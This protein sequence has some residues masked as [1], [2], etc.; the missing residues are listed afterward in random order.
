ML[1][2][3]KEKSSKSNLME[4]RTKTPTIP[5]KYSN[6]CTLCIS[7]LFLS[8][9]QPYI[10]YNTKEFLHFNIQYIRLPHPFSKAKNRPI[11]KIN[12]RNIS[13]LH[14]SIEY[15]M[16]SS[17][18][19][20]E[21]S[22]Q[23]QMK[24]SLREVCFPK[25]R[26][27][28]SRRRLHD[29]ERERWKEVH[30]QPSDGDPKDHASAHFLAW[31]Q[32]NLNFSHW[33]TL[34]TRSLS[35]LIMPPAA[36]KDHAYRVRAH[37]AP[38]PCSTIRGQSVAFISPPLSSHTL[39]LSFSLTYSMGRREGSI[40]LATTTGC[41][42]SRKISWDASE[43]SYAV[44]RLI[45]CFCSHIFGMFILYLR[46]SLFYICVSLYFILPFLF[47]YSWVNGLEFYVVLVFL[48]IW[49]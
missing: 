33:M 38:L 20:W 15:W 19:H 14:L 1:P 7:T 24:R 39:S 25:P 10:Q 32:T 40:L 28:R 17:S 26:W 41:C 8:C 46:F 2:L 21:L 35:P 31:L 11:L 22:L 44:F 45:L 16:P 43:F 18:G 3:V 34:G 37:I 23:K 49:H 4:R 48:F 42:L 47:I 5:K 27:F 29:L 12:M 13:H 36:F 30:L 6:A 9:P